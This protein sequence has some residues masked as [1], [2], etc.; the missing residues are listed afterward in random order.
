M[1]KEEEPEKEKISKKNVHIFF[2]LY[3]KLI[4]KEDRHF[5]YSGMLKQNMSSVFQIY[6]KFS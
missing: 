5:S 4:L 3:C 2:L 6:I 1:M